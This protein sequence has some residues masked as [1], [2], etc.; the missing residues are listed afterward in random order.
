MTLPGC[1]LGCKF[2]EYTRASNFAG[3]KQTEALYIYICILNGVKQSHLDP[4][5]L[6][7]EVPVKGKAFICYVTPQYTGL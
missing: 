1:S 7:G 3:S 5:V 2:E 6:F 4:D